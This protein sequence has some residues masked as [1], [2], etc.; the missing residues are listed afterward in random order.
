MINHCDV[1]FQEPSRNPS[2]PFFNNISQTF[3]SLS[4]S[5]NHL[6]SLWNLSFFCYHPVPFGFLHLRHELTSPFRFSTTSPRT[7][8]SLSFFYIFATNLPLPLLF[9]HLLHKLTSPFSFSTSLL[10]TYLSLSFFYIFATNLPLPFVFLHLRHE[11][12]SILSFFYIFATNLLLPLVFLHLCLELTSP[13]RFSTA[14]S[15]TYLSL[16]FFY[17]FATN[18]ILSLVFLHLRVE[19]TSPFRFLQL[20]I[21]S[22]PHLIL[23]QLFPNSAFSFFN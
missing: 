11:L 6:Q 12:T 15:C 22:P 21:N 10:R 9:V 23:P 20:S 13:F 16:L 18:L 14:L 8:I 2:F 1:F 3:L 7:Y 19:L 17:I 4:F 5:R